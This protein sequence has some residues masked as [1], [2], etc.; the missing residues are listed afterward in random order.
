MIFETYT[1][2]KCIIV[3]GVTA[4]SIESMCKHITMSMQEKQGDSHIWFKIRN[5]RHMDGHWNVQGKVH[6]I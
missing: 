6:Q 3:Y 1:I 4:Y 2:E 5:Y